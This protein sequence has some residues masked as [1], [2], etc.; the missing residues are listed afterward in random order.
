[1]VAMV[2][3]CG[4]CEVHVEAEETVE[5]RECGITGPDGVTTSY[6]INSWFGLKIKKRPMKE[7]VE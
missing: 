6:E 5:H 7:A 1:M 2:I 3:E 4:V